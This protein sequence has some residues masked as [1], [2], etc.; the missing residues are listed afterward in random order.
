MGGK[1]FLDKVLSFCPSLH[2]SRPIFHRPRKRTDGT[3]I[4]KVIN[5]G[6][7]FR[8]ELNNPFRR[9]TVHSQFFA[10]S[11]NI[12]ACTLGLERLIQTQMEIPNSMTLEVNIW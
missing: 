9:R 3:K 11:A 4:S 2:I 5:W 1:K 10:I 7:Y 12:L 6:E 8:L